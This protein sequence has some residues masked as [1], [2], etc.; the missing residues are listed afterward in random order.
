MDRCSISSLLCTALVCTTIVP[1]GAREARASVVI[2]EI[3]AGASERLV[4]WSQPDAPRIGSGV[5]WQSPLFDDAT[6]PRAPG[7]FDFGEGAGRTHVY[8]QMYKRACSLYLRQAFVV[9]PGDAPPTNRVF[10]SI[11]YDDGFI[12]YL[13]GRQVATR[14]LGR[15]PAFAYCDQPAYNATEA[16]VTNGIDLGAAG[17]LLVPGTNVLALQAH[18]LRSN[19]TD[20]TIIADLIL[21]GTPPR[22]LVAH[23]NEWACSVG[24]AEPSGGL[25]DH[26]VSGSEFLDWI[27]L[28][29]TGATPVSLDGW[30][31][32]DEAD[33]PLKWRFPAVTLTAGEYLVVLCSE[34]NRAD[35]TSRTFHTGF[36]LDADGEYV[37][38]RDGS[39]VVRDEF[40]DGYPPQSA[41]HSYGRLE[42]TDAWR[43][44]PTPTPGG[45]NAA[46]TA[47]EAM[48]AVPEFSTPG[49]F[50]HGIVGLFLTCAT[51]N[52]II[53]YTLDGSEP[54]ENTGMLY[55][56]PLFMTNTSIF[57]ARAFRTNW[58]PSRVSTRSYLY[59][60]SDTA[61]Q[62][63]VISLAGDP[64]YSLY[65]PYGIMAVQGG[66][67]S[68][69]IF[70]HPAVETDYNNMIMRGRAFERPATFELFVGGTNTAAQTDCG[71][72][73]SGSHYSRTRYGRGDDWITPYN[74]RNKVS[75]RLYFRGSYGLD[76]LEY[77]LFAPSHVE[78]FSVLTLRGMYG[79]RNPFIKDEL[80]RRLHIA[81]GHVGAHGSFVHI[82]LNGNW[83]GYY[84]LCERLDEH[85][86]RSWYDSTNDWDVFHIRA[87][88]SG[89]AV[90]WNHLFDLV[91][92]L[93]FGVLSNY[94]AVADL[95]DMENYVDYL[96]VNVY[97]AATDW[98]HNN[99][100]AARERVPGAKFRFY[101][102]DADSTFSSLGLDTIGTKLNTNSYPLANLFIHL[103]NSP[104]FR[105]LFA[106]RIQKHFFNGGALAMESV[107][108]Q[109]EAL[110]AIMAPQ[111]KLV[112]NE[113]FNYA[114]F[115][116]WMAQRPGIIF[117][118]FTAAGLWP[119][120]RAPEF[121]VHGGE[122]PRNFVCAITNVNATGTVYYTVDGS[123]PRLPGGA[124]AGTAYSGPL[125]L[126][127]PTLVKA[128]VLADGVWSPLAEASFM[129][130]TPLAVTEVMH[131]PPGG[132]DYEFIEVKNIGTEALDLSEI[133]FDEGITFAFKD[134]AV[135]TLAAGAC[136]VVARNT[137]AFA[138]RY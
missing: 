129:V 120:V 26:A 70:W 93:P 36:K 45:P 101:V 134:G 31:L 29:N 88:R 67:R 135:T 13:N 40:T 25:T 74:L 48:V 92:T 68:N 98:P 55:T 97:A 58:V 2:N 14:N 60:V 15:S 16:G 126:A 7:G 52:A 6:W 53:R 115:A 123:D 91:N 11:A 132:G 112:Y 105:L 3:S 86:Y 47:L 69:D 71:I 35:V 77:P 51:S 30:A 95:M 113:I 89:N 28:C 118:H 94:H 87:F 23:T 39:G 76:E 104:E 5:P 33:E 12:A 64:R 50:K 108:N 75:L 32:T 80:V 100:D 65:E 21:D 109:V 82:Y 10:L 37:A 42:G 136:A 99:F 8:T 1:A 54:R 138:A 44:L 34:H 119:G 27:E 24:V 85:F 96:L 59:N 122:V 46:G 63:P 84:N 79:G 114:L 4:D 62:L 107:S 131:D 106:D 38:L 103:T 133:A 102:W 116:N 137:T 83:K 49:G 121:N 43:Y 17:A 72:R 125:V 18:N 117:P 130:R 111:I 78:R 73:V 66:W 22:V 128:R 57:R 110:R 81:M 9:A 90:A 61:R 41:F 56:G 124:V 127:M 20:F 19:D